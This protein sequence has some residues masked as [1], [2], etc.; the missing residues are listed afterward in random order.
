MRKAARVAVAVLCLVTFSAVAA[1]ANDLA[2]LVKKAVETCTL[3]QPGTRPFHLKAEYAPSRERDN[4]SHRTGDI[5]IWWETPTKWRREVRSPE[6]HQVAIVDGEKQWQKNDGD[7]FPNWLR[8]LAVAIVRPVPLPMDVLL[9]RVKTAD[10][11]RIMGQTNIDWDPTSGPG[12]AQSNGKGYM[13]L[14]DQTGQ[15]F[16][17]GG[18]GWSG[19]YHDFKNFHGRMVAYTVASGYVEVTAKVSVLEDLGPTPSGFFDASAPGGDTQPIDTVVL[20]EAELSKNLLPGKPIVWPALTDGPLEGVVWT[21]VV[22]DRTGKIRETHWP[23]SDNPG[24]CGAADEVFH[25]MRFSPIV[26]NGVPVQA[27][28]RLSLPFKTVRP[29]GRETFDSA[30]N[31][32]ERG[33]KLSF[34]FAGTS[35]PYI[36][37]ADFQTGTRDGVQTG[38]YV[39]IWISA[40]EWKREA[41]L[42]SSHLVRSHSGEKYYVLAEGPDAALLRLVMQ[43]MEPIP[44]VDTMTE[45]DWRIRRDMVDGVKT[46]RVFRG[47][48]GPNGEPEPGHSNGYWFDESGRLVKSYTQGMEILPLNVEAYGGVLVARQIDVLK[49]GKLGMFVVVKE[50]GPADTEAAK[51]FKLKGHEWQRAFTSE[52]R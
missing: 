5:E 27:M 11:R 40:T 43:L 16:Y 17:T 42:G 23:I 24:L 1:Q 28:G 41:W 32:F 37:R 52:V 30:R 36:L 19:Q 46:I 10:V 44:A 45:S 20:D 35:E 22:L 21:D 9:Q 4:D 50:V 29:A 3:D 39:D 48:E 18:P 12:D 7:F 51:S 8:E 6:F 47:P 14:M 13:A 38:Y 33:R 15:L 26:R 25:A 31:Y 49:D 2:K 34:L